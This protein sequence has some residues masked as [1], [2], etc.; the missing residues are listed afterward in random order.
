M[1]KSGPVDDWAKSK[2]NSNG[3]PL[4]EEPRPTAEI[5]FDEKMSFG[6]GFDPS[7]WA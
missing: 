7:E 3:G 6:S 2:P 4:P 1:G 5:E